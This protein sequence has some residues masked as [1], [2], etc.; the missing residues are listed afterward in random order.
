MCSGKVYYDLVKHR[1]TKKIDDVA[2]IRVE[3]LSPFP[4]RALADELDKY[5][6]AD[7]Y[8]WAQEEPQNAGMWDYVAP[9][10]S[11]LS[12]PVRHLRPQSTWPL[13]LHF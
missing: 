3:E 4:Y 10:F 12:A 13:V 5:R 7:S 8:R 2:I 11:R 1:E 9:R 6:N